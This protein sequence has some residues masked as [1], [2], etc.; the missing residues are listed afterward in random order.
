[1]LGPC[2]SSFNF[3][4]TSSYDFD[5]NSS[6][7]SGIERSYEISDFSLTPRK[8]NFGSSCGQTKLRKR[9]Y[10]NS[11]VTIEEFQELEKEFQPSTEATTSTPTK[12]KYAQ[13]K[14]RISRSQSPTQITKIRKY[15]R[16]KANDRE[17]NRMHSLNEALERL[18]LTLP[19]LPQD[20]KLTKIETLRFAHNYIFALTQVV[21]H[22]Y[23]LKTFDIEKLQSLTLSGEKVTKELFEALFINPSPYCSQDTSGYYA[24]Y[25]YT[26]GFNSS[27]FE[28]V[29]STG[30]YQQSKVIDNNNINVKNYE[31][32]KGAF[33]TA[34]HSGRTYNTELTSDYPCYDNRYYQGQ[35]F[36]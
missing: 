17:R 6:L 32:F 33:E 24:S 21:E 10:R 34:V 13:G 1:M 5:D 29:N 8:L 2:N 25:N 36:Y 16:I 14:S 35:N 27:N 4:D 31:L 19:T 15:R 20:T 26:N 12:R 7:D 3:E 23:S 22:G 9:N 18:R 11:K 30:F 28:N